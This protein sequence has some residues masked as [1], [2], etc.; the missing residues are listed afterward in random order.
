MTRLPWSMKV[1]SQGD[2]KCLERPRPRL[3]TWL[4]P[5]RREGDK[6]AASQKGVESGPE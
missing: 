6:K 5:L 2:K 4:A 1:V 3:R